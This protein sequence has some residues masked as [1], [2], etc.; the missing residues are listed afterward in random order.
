DAGPSGAKFSALWQVAGDEVERLHIAR[1]P[2]YDLSDPNDPVKNWPVWS[3]YDK[4]TGTLT[5]PALRN[6]GEK[7]L[8]DGAIIWSEADFLMA[9]ARRMHAE[10]N[11]DPVAGSITNPLLANSR[12]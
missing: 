2:G 3:A 7:N 5:S 6:L 9:S 12:W 10:W 1:H 4:Q 11:Y 8:L